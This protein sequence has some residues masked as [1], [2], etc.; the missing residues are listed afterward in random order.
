MPRIKVLDTFAVP[1]A[2]YDV[3]H[4]VGRVSL[5]PD[6]ST[7][8]EMIV[9]RAAGADVLVVNKTPLTAAVLARLEGVALVAETASGYDNIDVEAAAACGITVCN[10]PG[11]STR[12]VA[13]HVFALV[14]AARRKLFACRRHVEEGGWVEESLLGEELGGK[15]MG[16][17]GFGKI[18]RAVSALA[19]AF[20]MEVMV[21]TRTPAKYRGEYPEVRWVG[22][23]ELMREA[24]V[25]TVHVPCTPET[26]GMIS[27]R[28][29][30]AMK[31]GAL[32]VNTARG[33]VVDEEALAHACA[34]GR[35]SACV[36]VT[37]VE[38]PRPDNPLLG[39]PNVIV[40]PHVA[41]Y[42]GESVER[43]LEVTR[44]NIASFFAGAPRNVVAAP[45]G[46]RGG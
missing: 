12:S 1:V 33:R 29:L 14:L 7:D 44:D 19:R 11:Y 36:D 4:S 13:E 41:W 8:P 37:A 31:Q 27:A 3:L 5:F 32:F 18:G 2:C 30:E 43:L 21:H 23:E 39:L 46:S 17:V 16:I 38:P 40:T 20:G 34:S 22:I 42:T 35:I 9:K 28:L 10:V 24:D 26:E 25:V 45:P 6:V 15:T